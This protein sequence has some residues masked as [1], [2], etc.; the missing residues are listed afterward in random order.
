MALT[1]T[2][3]EA[4]RQLRV[5]LK[6]ERC[7]FDRIG[8]WA[9]EEAPIPVMEKDVTP[10]I[11]KRTELW[12]ESWVFPLIDGLL[13]EISAG[14]LKH[15]FLPNLTRC[16][17]GEHNWSETEDGRDCPRCGKSEVLD[18]RVVDAVTG[19]RH[20]GRLAQDG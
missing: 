1:K 5:H 7:S 12:R 16:K 13:N 20:K 10:F 4:L 14:E 15:L 9:R 2:Q 19:G 17:P 6:M 11:R 8:P 3:K 18:T